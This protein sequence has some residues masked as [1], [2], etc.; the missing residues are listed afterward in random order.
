[1][2][3]SK[4]SSIRRCGSR[5][6]NSM[7]SILSVQNKDSHKPKVN[8]TDHSFEFGKACEDLSWNH[9]T[10][11]PHRSE[12]NGIAERAV[13]R[14]REGTSGVMVDG[15]HGVLLMSARHSR[16]LVCWEDTTCKAVRNAFNGP[17]IP[18]GAMVVDHP[19]FCQRPVATAS[20]RQESLTRNILRLCVIRGRNLERRHFGRRHWGV[21]KDGR[22]RKPRSETNAMEVLTL[23][24]GDMFIFPITDGKVKLSGGD[25]V[26]RNIHL[27]TGQPW[28]RRRAGRSSWRIRLGL[29]QPH[30]K[31]HRRMMVKQKKILVHFRELH[32]TVITLNRES[33]ST[34]REKSHPNSTTIHWRD[35]GYKY[36]LGCDAR[37]AALTIIVISMDQEICL[38]LGQASLSL[39]Y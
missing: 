32:L 15:F 27:D 22:I 8:Y 9:C 31:T 11:T 34:C 35:Q 3:I 2:W 4:Q 26:L 6:G 12:I 33:N 5:F 20:V 16:S 19:Y 13:R 1:M 38:I 7:D 29:L 10:S 24:N 39:F 36:D 25:Q 18:F 23:Q 28:T 37:N 14:T 30:F 21:V 17:V